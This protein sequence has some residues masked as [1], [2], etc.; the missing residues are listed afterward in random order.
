MQNLCTRRCSFG[1]VLASCL[2]T[3]SMRRI[4]LSTGLV[5]FAV[6]SFTSMALCVPA[7]SWT[8]GRTDLSGSIMSWLVKMECDKNACAS[9]FQWH[10][11][12]CQLWSD[13]SRENGFFTIFIF[14]LI[15]KS[16]SCWSVLLQ[17]LQVYPLEVLKSQ[18][19][20]SVGMYES[21]NKVN[22]LES[23]LQ[24][25]MHDKN[26]SKSSQKDCF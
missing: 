14:L 12:S 16:A 13:H 24:W 26:I 21:I 1:Y 15:S 23:F 6:Y 19:V 18:L 9:C 25:N 17:Q 3:L 11:H 8:N 5:V 2:K 4:V 7:D 22:I 20:T 10:Q